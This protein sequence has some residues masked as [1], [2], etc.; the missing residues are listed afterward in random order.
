MVVSVDS[1]LDNSSRLAEITALKELHSD[2]TTAISAHNLLSSSSLY[3]GEQEDD[4]YR[5]LKLKL[6]L[7]AVPE[8]DL[9]WS[10]RAELGKI[11]SQLQPK[12]N[13]QKIFRVVA[14]PM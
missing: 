4:V 9:S 12:L 5:Y 11:H 2:D 13:F 1:V 3:G 10:K 14:F 8:L 6:L 7:S